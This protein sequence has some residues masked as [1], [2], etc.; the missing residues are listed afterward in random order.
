VKALNWAVGRLNQLCGGK[1]EDRAFGNQNG[2]IP[3]AKG[4]QTIGE[5]LIRAR[6]R[7]GSA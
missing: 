7:R 4:G 2:R 1:G 5:N 3:F 6:V